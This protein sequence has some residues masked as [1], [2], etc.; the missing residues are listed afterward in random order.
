MCNI[1]VSSDWLLYLTVCACSEGANSND[2]GS[3]RN[4]LVASALAT[5]FKHVGYTSVKNNV[6]DKWP[7]FVGKDKKSG[8]FGSKLKTK[9]KYLIKN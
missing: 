2:E 3:E 1:C 5:F 7:T 4:A 9:V 6:L 8:F